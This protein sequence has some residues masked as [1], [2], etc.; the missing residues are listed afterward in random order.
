MTDDRFGGFYTSDSVPEE[1]NFE[2]EHKTRTKLL[3]GFVLDYKTRLK[4]TV[5]I[6]QQTHRICTKPEISSNWSINL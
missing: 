6:Y 4:D 1:F 2:R 3:K 5:F